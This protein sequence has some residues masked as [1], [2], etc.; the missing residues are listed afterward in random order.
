VVVVAH[1]SRGHDQGAVLSV[2]DARHLQA[3]FFHYSASDSKDAILNKASKALKNTE[4][5]WVRVD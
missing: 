5:I 1:S 3:A 2:K 4:L